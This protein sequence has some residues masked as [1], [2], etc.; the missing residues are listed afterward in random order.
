MNS[1][2][3]FQQIAPPNYLKNHIKSFWFFGQ[4][5]D[6]PSMLKFSPIPDGFAGLIFQLSEKSFFH[7][8][9]QNEMSKVFIYRPNMERKQML[10]KG[11]ISTIGV[12]F[13]PS[14]IKTIFGI[15]VNEISN[16][17][18]DFEL[19]SRK[20]HQNLTE[21]VSRLDNV[22]SQ[23][24]LLSR[25]FYKKIEANTLNSQKIDFAI[26]QIINSKGQTSIHDILKTLNISERSLERHF[27]Q[28][29]GIN[30]NTYSRLC[31]FSATIQDIKNLDYEKLTDIAYKFGYADQSHFIREFKKFSGNSPLQFINKKEF[32]PDLEVFSK[33]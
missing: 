17:C 15:D 21:N 14:A 18:L 6:A 19:I 28:Y 29:V 4:K 31:R 20:E 30:P 33:P 25:Y 2:F 3:T 27:K 12:Y 23:I 1:N 11:T 16:D 10:L 24:E 8:M 26:N 22:Q 32:L 5:S 13:Y 7:D 9:E